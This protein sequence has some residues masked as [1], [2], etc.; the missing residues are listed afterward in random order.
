MVIEQRGCPFFFNFVQIAVCCEISLIQS[1]LDHIIDVVFLLFAAWLGFWAREL[2]KPR[3]NKTTNFFGL[4][5]F[6]YDRFFFVNQFRACQVLVQY[7][8]VSCII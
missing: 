1:S 7:L 5:L 4:P 8:H 6:E 3:K 2:P